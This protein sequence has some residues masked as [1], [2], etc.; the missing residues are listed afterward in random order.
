MLVGIYVELIEPCSRLPVLVSGRRFFLSL[1]NL[2]CLNHL[3]ASREF[4][5]IG[6]HTLLVGGFFVEL[7]SDGYSESIITRPI[8]RIS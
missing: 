4:L 3:A 7:S 6:T 5:N 8:T 1:L 2:D